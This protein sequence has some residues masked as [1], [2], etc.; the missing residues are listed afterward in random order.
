MN[1][2]APQTTKQHVLLVAARDPSS[3][4]TADVYCEGISSVSAADIA[5]A[6]DAGFVIK[7]L[8]IARLDR[9]VGSQSS[10]ARARTYMYM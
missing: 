4:T 10:V 3:V 8:A 7:L 2:N 9:R 6:K 5:A 1:T